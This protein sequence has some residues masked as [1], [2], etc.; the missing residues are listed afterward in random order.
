MSSKNKVNA[1]Y[2]WLDKKNKT[3][4]KMK[5]NNLLAKRRPPI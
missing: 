1:P 2:L 5:K 4:N 3:V